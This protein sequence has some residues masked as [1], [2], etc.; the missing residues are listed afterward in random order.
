MNPSPTRSLDYTLALLARLDLLIRREVLNLRQQQPQQMDDEFRGLY[1]ANE[2]VDALLD[3]QAA[4]AAV[5][6]TPRPPSEVLAALDASLSA[7]NVR[8]ADIETQAR[9]CGETLRINRL[10]QLFDLSD[11]E[12]AVLV[13]CLAPEIN[14]KYER[15]YAYLHDDVTKKRPTVDLVMRLLCRTVAERVTARQAFES[16]APLVKWELVT[17]HDDPNARRPVLIARYLKLDERIARYLLGYDEI[18]TRLSTLAREPHAYRAGNLAPEIEA[19]LQRWGAHWRE[20]WSD[21]PPIILFHG[22]YGTGTRDAARLLASALQRPLLHFDALDLATK[23]ANREQ[24]LKLAEREGLL[25]DALVCWDDADVFLHA[26]PGSENEHRMFTQALEQSR[27]PIV[28]LANKAWEPAHELGHRPFLRLELSDP[29]YAERRATWRAALSANPLSSEERGQGGEVVTDADLTAL[30]GRFRLT[31]G[32]IHDAVARAR[33][34]AWVR[35]PQNGHLTLSDIDMACRNQAQHRLGTLARKLNPR[36]VWDDI[37]L[38]RLQLSTLRMIC[39]TIRQRPVVYG[40]WGFDRKLALGKGLIAL[41]SGPSGTGKT[42]AGEIIANDLGLDVYKID[43]SSVVS[44]YIG[45]TEK[46]LEKI[47]SEAQD[48]DSILFFDEAD[49]LFGKRSEVKDA[50]DRYANIETAYLL[51]RTEEYNGLVILASNIKKNMDEA[52]VRRIHFMVDFPF[53]EEAE[54]YEIWRRTFP[55]EAP[56]DADIDYEFLARKF[57][58]TGGSIRNIILAAAFSAADERAPIAMRHLVRGA[59]YEFQKMGKLVVEG[60]FEQYFG[61]ART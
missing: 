16:D 42:M 39:T 29:S 46:N 44:K 48:S 15:L 19:R 45:E 2:E 43:L 24:A 3:N 58:I 60:D 37:V 26:Q 28:L 7:A 23:G 50:H 27:V 9:E 54:R 10:C 53:P 34:L 21:A 38:P 61:M 49:A 56:Q 12:R 47:F 51:Q 40:D 32:Q 22:R 20:A 5:L 4:V 30:T 31:T 52:F 25:A 14:L 36:Y 35:D 8:L 59:G 55:P 17:L 57:K 13:I 41:F 6:S 11:L 33:T 18:D 1:I